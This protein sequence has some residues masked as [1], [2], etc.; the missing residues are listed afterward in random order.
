[1]PWRFDPLHLQASSLLINLYAQD[2]D[3]AKA[4]E[5]SQRILAV[6]QPGSDAPAQPSAQA[7]PK[8]A[9]TVFKNLKV[10][11][12]VPSDQIIPSMRF[13]TSSLG[14]RCS[15]CHVEGRFE[16]DAKKE[17]EVARDMMRMMFAINQNNFEGTRKVTCNSCHR[18]APKPMA[19]P[20]I[21]IGPVAALESD[22][23]RKEETL[24]V[25][26]PTG[27]EL[28]D[29]TFRHLAVRLRLRRLRLVSKMAASKPTVAQLVWKFPAKSPDKRLLR[30]THRQ[31]DNV[32]G[33]D[34][35]AGWVRT[36]S[37]SL[38]DLSGSDLDAARIDADLQ[39]ALHIKQD[40]PELRVEYPKQSMAAKAYVMLG[41][42]ERQ[43]PWRF[44]FDA[45][46]GLLVRIVRSSESPLGLD[47]YA[48]RLPGL[49]R[50]GRCANSIHL[51]HRS[52]RRQINLPHD[53]DSTECST[54]NARSRNQ[55]PAGRVISGDS[56][57][58]TSFS[59]SRNQFQARL[60]ATG[61]RLP[62]WT[63]HSRYLPLKPFRD[64]MAA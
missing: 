43:A 48:D 32:T 56:S 57:D 27:N 11:S 38:R 34:G 47:P 5:L 15:F 4:G 24:P 58:P 16:D 45:Q 63:P 62:G 55:L 7:S 30:S 60:R 41:I 51:D 54:D 14:V 61:I 17:K 26:L 2:G 8:T 22:P 13:I 46:S 25:G 1:M 6:M 20:A 36:P 39:F 9:G 37:G 12:D 40:F 42:R 44:Y 59:A 3:S 29:P 28:V 50:S 10:L 19:I 21:G 53:G 33:L 52:R 49:P 23:G 18:G 31:G 35:N 64:G